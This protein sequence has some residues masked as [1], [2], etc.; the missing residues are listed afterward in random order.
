MCFRYRFG[1]RFRCVTVCVATTG[2]ICVAACICSFY[3]NPL[4]L[5]FA[6]FAHKISGLQLEGGVCLQLE[7]GLCSA[8]S[9]RFLFPFASQVSVS[10]ACS[11]S[12]TA[13]AVA[14]GRRA[15]RHNF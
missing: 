2:Q 7:S 5:N 13:A 6:R 15:N 3:R 11:F 9:F 1:L 14:A 12:V 10:A 8:A 4:A